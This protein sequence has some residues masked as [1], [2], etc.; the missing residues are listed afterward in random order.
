MFF[1]AHHQTWVPQGGAEV[2]GGSFVELDLTYRS[3]FKRIKL[4]LDP[5]H[6]DYLEI[7]LYVHLTTIQ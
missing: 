2:G 4:Y 3:K 7:H 6:P 1:V 5:I